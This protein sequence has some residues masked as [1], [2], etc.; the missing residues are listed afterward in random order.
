MKKI[1]ILLFLAVF[2][3]LLLCGCNE[4]RSRIRVS[5][6]SHNSRCYSCHRVYYGHISSHHCAPV[7]TRH[8]SPPVVHY[9][10]SI[11]VY[12]R[13]FMSHR[14]RMPGNGRKF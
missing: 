2:L 5:Y 10:P 13:S 12:R 8:F 3:L 14:N 6:N 9:R 1:N 4:G 7:I 11:I